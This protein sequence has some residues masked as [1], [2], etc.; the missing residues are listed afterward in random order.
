MLPF[1]SSLGSKHSTLRA[2]GPLLALWGHASGRTA[3]I[4]RTAGICIPASPRSIST[5]A[6]HPSH[7][8]CHRCCSSAF[9]WQ[10][11]HSRDASLK[12]R[13]MLSIITALPVVVYQ[14]PCLIDI[15][16][17]PGVGRDGAWWVKCETRHVKYLVDNEEKTSQAPDAMAR[18]VLREGAGSTKGHGCGE[19][20]VQCGEKHATAKTPSIQ[21]SRLINGKVFFSFSTVLE[22][23]NGMGRQQRM[24]FERII[25]VGA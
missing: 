3:S 2:S 15:R 12:A 18:A 1:P 10:A 6:N 4:P 17:P 20:A 8:R 25:C 5:S 9:C 22:L 23:P 21:T 7:K 16:N 24:G 19:V 13:P 11:Q 14:F